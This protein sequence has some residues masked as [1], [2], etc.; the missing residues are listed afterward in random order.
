MAIAIITIKLMMDSPDT[1]LP[2]VEEKAKEIIKGI[3]GEFYKTETEE[4]AFGL[5][6]L[7]LT[8]TCDEKLGSDAFEEKLKDIE[9]VSN[10]QCVDF[11]RALG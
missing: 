9:G 5:K 11:R 2:E 3:G 1:N 7:K 10:A 6:A 4:I 8:F